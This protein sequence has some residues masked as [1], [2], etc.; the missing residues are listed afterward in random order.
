MQNLIFTLQI[1][2][3]GVVTESHVVGPIAFETPLQATEAVM[4]IMGSSA[5]VPYNYRLTGGG[6][7][8]PLPSIQGGY[9]PGTCV[10]IVQIQTAQI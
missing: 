1:F 9:G 7:K 3:D 4:D 10:N 8:I 5:R 2:Q 6:S